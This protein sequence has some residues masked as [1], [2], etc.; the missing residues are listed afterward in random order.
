MQRGVKITLIEN[1]NKLSTKNEKTAIKYRFQYNGVYVNLYFDNY[2]VENPCLCMILN[3]EKYYYYTSLNVNRPEVEKEYLIGIPSHILDKILNE[4]KLDNFFE[5]IKKHILSSNF[6]TICYD[7]D[8]TFINT[9][10][11]NKNED[12]LPFLHYLK[13]IRM[14]DKN[15]YLLSKTMGLDENIL[16]KIQ[17]EGFTIVRTA[18]P[19]K[20]KK[21]TALMQEKKI[22]I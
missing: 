4:N 21:L 8:K 16:I 2:D 5:G 18:N 9:L 19:N 6:R 14:S 22:E 20:R 3:Y 1:Y 11:Y 10:K 7:N 13:K 12:A 15:L 17:L